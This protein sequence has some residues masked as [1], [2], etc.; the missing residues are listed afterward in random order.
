MAI[1]GS[2]VGLGNIWRF[3]YLTGENGGA[4]FLLLYI[5]LILIV[6]LPL[7]LSEFILGQASRRGTVGAFKQLAPKR[8]WYLVGYMGVT[9]GFFILGFYSVIAGWSIRFLYDSIMDVHAGMSVIEIE[10][11]FRAFVN[12]GWQ[13]VLLSALFLCATAF[14]VFKGVEKG[15]ERWNKILMPMLII[16]LIILALHSITL[17]GFEEGMTFLFAPD[18]SKITT[19]TV[20]DALGQVFFSLSLGMGIMITYSSYVVKESNMLRTLGSITIIDTV[21]ALTAGIAIFPAVF[22]FG[23]APEQGPD[24]IFLTLPNVFGQMPA[25]QYLSSLFFLLITIAALTSMVSIFEMLTN[26]L[27]EELRFKRRNA[28]LVLLGTLIVIS[29][30]CALSQMEDTKLYIGKYNVFDFLDVLS[31]NYLMTIGGFLI[32]IFTGW[33]MSKK[34]LWR[35]FTSRGKYNR[36]LFPIYLFMV[37]FIAPVAVALIFLTKVG[38]IQVA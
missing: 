8:K 7:I 31:A 29:A 28:V 12:T 23:I 3:P 35:T 5:L 15:V 37:R 21:I 9:A 18:F 33:I 2:A 26:Y 36:K 38:L 6:G 10:A 17:S 20:L 24:L 19:G 30:L 11:G 14:V 13:P 1:V 22:T 27:M 34:R 4:A 25:G 32:A 16:I